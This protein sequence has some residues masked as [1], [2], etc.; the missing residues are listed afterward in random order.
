MNV[1]SLRI[2]TV[3][4][5][6]K[7]DNTNEKYTKINENHPRNFQFTSTQKGPRKLPQHCNIVR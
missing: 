1:S 2:E 6:E 7:D 4:P 5:K 3:D